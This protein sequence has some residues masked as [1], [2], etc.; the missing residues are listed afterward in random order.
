MSLMSRPEILGSLDIVPENQE[1]KI[2]GDPHALSFQ[3]A[4]RLSILER[5]QH[6]VDVHSPLPKNLDGDE[7]SI[8]KEAID[9]TYS[10]ICSAKAARRREQ[11]KTF[12]PRHREPAE[13]EWCELRPYEKQI[14]AIQGELYSIWHEEYY[15]PLSSP[16]DKKDFQVW[17]D[18]YLRKYGQAALNII[19]P[20]N[21][22][23]N[24]VYRPFNL[25]GR[26]R[27]LRIARADIT[28]IPLYGARAV[29]II[30][31]EDTIVRIV[32]PQAYMSTPFIA[33]EEGSGNFSMLDIGTPSNYHHSDIFSLDSIP[34]GDDLLRVRLPS[35]IEMNI[36]KSA[37]E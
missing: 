25:E 32:P 11:L 18:S 6:H 33:F 28:L 26:D 21:S 14:S 24:Q 1:I 4:Q 35:D 22:E 12:S 15:E 29:Q 31:P 2:E 3:I 17:L 8:V 20:T 23:F 16:A 37:L 13:L 5:F 27:D 36:G 34:G 30:E 7:V 10:N 19:K 9:K